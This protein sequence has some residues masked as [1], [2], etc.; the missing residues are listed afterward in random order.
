MCWQANYLYACRN[1]RLALVKVQQEDVQLIA[2]EFEL[3]SKV[4]EVRLRELDGNVVAA[5]KSFL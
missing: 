2:T 5:L 1:Q 4:A 3:S